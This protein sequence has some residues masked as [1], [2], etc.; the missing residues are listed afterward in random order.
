VTKYVTDRDGYKVVHK[1][2]KPVEV[3]MTPDEIRKRNLGAKHAQSTKTDLQREK[4]KK[5]RDASIKN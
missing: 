3:K 1:D 4:A 5:K 2:G